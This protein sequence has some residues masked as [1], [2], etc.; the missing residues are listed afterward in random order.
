MGV[1]YSYLFELRP[2]EQ[3]WDGFLLAENLVIA[4]LMPTLFLL[5]SFK[6]YTSKPKKFRETREVVDITTYGN[7]ILISFF[8]FFVLQISNCFSACQC[9][10]C[11]IS[12]IQLSDSSNC[13]RNLWSCKSNC[14]AYNGPSWCQLPKGYYGR[15]LVLQLLII[16]QK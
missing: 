6:V 4:F 2:E 11:L 13:S 8:L 15:G 14:N 3:V 5:F 1:K 16:Q 7:I 9:D 12:V 10:E